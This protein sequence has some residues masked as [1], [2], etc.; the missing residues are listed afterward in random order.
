MEHHVTLSMEFMVKSHYEL[1]RTLAAER[2]A[3]VHAS[4]VIGRLPDHGPDLG[5]REAALE[6]ALD[7]MQ[8]VA[9]YLS[10]LG[11]LEEAVADQLEIVLKDIPFAEGNE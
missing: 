7:V 5:E 10:S 11:D 6:L 1:A 2:D 3:A 8:S 4:R 9:V